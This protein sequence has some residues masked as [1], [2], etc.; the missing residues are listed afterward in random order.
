[1]SVFASIRDLAL[2]LSRMHMHSVTREPHEGLNGQVLQLRQLLQRRQGHPSFV[3]SPIVW[4]RQYAC[5]R[6]AGRVD[7]GNGLMASSEKSSDCTDNATSSQT[8]GLEKYAAKNVF[9]GFNISLA[10][11]SGYFRNVCSSWLRDCAI[12]LM[13]IAHLL[14]PV[15]YLNGLCISRESPSKSSTHSRLLA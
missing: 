11:K 9:F 5:H 14:G 8:S 2:A 6:H 12:E 15:S 3:I 1:M 13:A 7:G 4:W 10:T